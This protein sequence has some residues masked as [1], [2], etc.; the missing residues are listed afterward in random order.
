[1]TD[2][3]SI[4]K[5]VVTGSGCEIGIGAVIEDGVVLGDGVRIGHGAV[6]LSG[7]RLGDG[8]E[9]GPLSVLGKQPQAAASSTREV[10][11]ATPLVFGTGC[12]IG[13]S[14]VIYAGSEF[15]PGCY[16]GDLAG[17]RESGSFAEAVL[18]GRMVSVEAD[19]K[20]G[21]RSRVMTG[22]YVTGETVLEE[23]VFL[24]PK[25]ITTNDRY[26]SMWKEPVF[27]GPTVKARAA[28]GAGACLLSGITVG[29][30]A[31]VG[32]GAVVIE[33]IPAGRVYVG[34]PAR[35]AGEA[36]SA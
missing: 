1:M 27:Q 11:A 12:V 7:T 33:D 17:V 3:Y 25:V 26:L 18:I 35:D 22:G 31:V 16:V 30:G 19:V 24:G 32:M 14:A 2:G 36:R 8:V 4:G 9:V 5:D 23:D 6:V 10:S 15:G 29:E 28:V 21:A 20:I 34:V 13:S